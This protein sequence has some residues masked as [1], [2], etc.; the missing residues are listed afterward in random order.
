MECLDAE[1][2]LDL[3]HDGLEEEAC[4]AIQDGADAVGSLEEGTE[5]GTDEACFLTELAPRDDEEAYD[6]D[7]VHYVK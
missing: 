6:E 4:L 7:F 2:P 1:T 3:H 5:D